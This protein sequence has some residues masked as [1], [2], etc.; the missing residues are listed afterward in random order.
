MMDLRSRSRQREI[1]VMAVVL[2]FGVVAW[3]QWVHS[4]ALG[5]H[6]DSSGGHLLP[7]SLGW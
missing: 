3:E 1:M 6:H 5:V 4:S 2:A 7:S